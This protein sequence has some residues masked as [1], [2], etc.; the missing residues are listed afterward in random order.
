MT[1]SKKKLDD[2]LFAITFSSVGL[3]FPYDK[4]T[5]CRKMSLCWVLLAVGGEG[6]AAKTR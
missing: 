2:K 6:R 4:D 1:M 5:D 3:F